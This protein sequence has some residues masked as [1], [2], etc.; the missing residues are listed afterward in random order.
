VDERGG[1][2]VGRRGGSLVG[3]KVEREGLKPSSS[4][5]EARRGREAGTREE[6]ERTEGQRTNSLNSSPFLLILFSYPHLITSQTHP[7]YSLRS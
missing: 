6:G 4:S 7:Y 5:D 3:E 2:G 1:H